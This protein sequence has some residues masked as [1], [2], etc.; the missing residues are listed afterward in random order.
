MVTKIEPVN[1]KMP[2]LSKSAL[3]IG[4]WLSAT[5]FF[6]NL[7]KQSRR[8]RKKKKFMS[9]QAK[10]EKQQEQ[11]VEYEAVYTIYKNGLKEIEDC[12]LELQHAYVVAVDIVDLDN[13]LLDKVSSVLEFFDWLKEEG[14][15]L[16]N[17]NGN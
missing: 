15:E 7:A 17:N 10:E 1:I 12:I 13:D 2:N 16:E 8:E 5:M 3:E 11:P 14:R 6:N 9:E 4:G